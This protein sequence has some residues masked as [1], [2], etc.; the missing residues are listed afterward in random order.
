M[1]ELETEKLKKLKAARAVMDARIR[2]EQ[3][4]LNE[5]ERRKETRRLILWGRWASQK[6]KRDNQFAAM[7]TEELK[8]Y[9]TR[10]DER[11]LLGFP[12]L[13]DAKKEE[14]PSVH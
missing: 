3:Q 6:A 5:A 11:A 13:T 1:A 7:A 14:R 4:K 8:G 9:F 2:Q 10:N 12:P